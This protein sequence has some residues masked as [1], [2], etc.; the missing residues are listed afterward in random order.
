MV[1]PNAAQ[2]VLNWSL[3][4]GRTAHNV[5]TGRYNGAFAGS[6]SQST[7]LFTALAGASQFAPMGAFLSTTTIF[8]GLTVRDLGVANQPLI[9]STGAGPAGTAAGG[10]LPN[11]VAICVTF[12]TAFTGPQNR[13][14]MYLP[15]WATQALGAGNTIA[16]T[17]VT[18]VSNWASIIAGALAASGYTLSIAHPARQAYIGSTGTQHPARVA[19]TVPVTTVVV[20]DNHWDSQRRRGLK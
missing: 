13:G 17:T 19:G 20:R 7:A 15:G 8:T 11:E 10:E 1:I 4:S 9:A 12:R 2:I 16:A 6:V 18:A 14:R 5:L 3:G